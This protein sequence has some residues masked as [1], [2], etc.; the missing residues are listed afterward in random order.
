M[1]TRASSNFFMLR[2]IKHADAALP[3]KQAIA[4]R[5]KGFPHR[6]RL[7]GLWPDTS[8]DPRSGESA[9]PEGRSARGI[10]SSEFRA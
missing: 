1:A 8:V 5:S 4:R 3:C 2:G 6:G 9:E 10:R 7:H